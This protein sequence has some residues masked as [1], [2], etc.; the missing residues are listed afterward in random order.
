MSANKND[1]AFELIACVYDI[2]CDTYHNMKEWVR[3]ST[4]TRTRQ[5][6]FSKAYNVAAYLCVTICVTNN[7][8]LLSRMLCDYF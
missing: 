5:F 7:G 3:T 6:G 2:A 1:T 4:S 8:Q